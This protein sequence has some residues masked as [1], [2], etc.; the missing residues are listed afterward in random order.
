MPSSTLT[1]SYTFHLYSLTYWPWYTHSAKR[2]SLVIIFAANKWLHSWH[3]SSILILCVCVHT[4]FIATLNRRMF[5]LYS[6]CIG[7]VHTTCRAGMVWD[8]IHFR[9]NSQTS[10]GYKLR[11][12]HQPL[13][14]PKAPVVPQ[15]S[16]PFQSSYIHMLTQHSDY[17]S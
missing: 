7:Y 5:V 6:N 14:R 12:L 9:G 2:G 11:K 4:P 3:M 16:W 1:S 10:T 8:T 13:L 15:S 17:A